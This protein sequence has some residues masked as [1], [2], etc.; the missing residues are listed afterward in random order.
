MS[1]I[2]DMNYYGCLNKVE[3]PRI[4]YSYGCQADNMTGSLMIDTKERIWENK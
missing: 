2:G 1:T 3:G 4:Y